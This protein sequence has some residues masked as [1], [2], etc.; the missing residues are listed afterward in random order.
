MINELFNKFCEL[1]GVDQIL[2]IILCISLLLK[3]LRGIFLYFVTWF[4]EHKKG[5]GTCKFFLD[6]KK[7]GECVNIIYASKYFVQQGKI[8]AH[9]DC[10]GYRAKAI[11]ANDIFQANW[12]FSSI[13]VLVDWGIQLPSI[14][15]IIRT[16]LEVNSK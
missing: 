11:H 3:L 10:P 8:C 16:L 5:N 14:L 12:L 13:A 6:N 2:L 9:R 4:F 15:L 7:S 1:S